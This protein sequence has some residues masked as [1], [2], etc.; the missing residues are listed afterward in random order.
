[1]ISQPTKGKTIK[2]TTNKATKKRKPTKTTGKSRKH[3]KYGTSKL[4]ERF[5][6]NFLDKLGVNYIKQFEAKDIKRFY[7]FYLPDQ[8]V[9][10]EVDG[11]YYHSYGKVYEEMSPMQ[12][13][14]ARVDKLKNT[15]ALMHGIPIMRIWEHDINNNPEK[16][17]KL[18]K[19]TLGVSTKKKIILD[20]KKKRH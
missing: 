20:N 9:L 15:W 6:K 4:E 1:M 19:E 5:A 12:K 11:D 3:P 13:R 10:I 18:L 8:R 16:V 17:M 2:K 14:N 7:D